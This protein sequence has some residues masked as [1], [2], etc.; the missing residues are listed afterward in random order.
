MGMIVVVP[1]YRH[2]EMAKILYSLKSFDRAKLIKLLDDKKIRYAAIGI[3]SIVI[4]SIIST[5][6]I[7]HKEDVCRGQTKEAFTDASREW[8]DTMNRASHSARITIGSSIS[9]L[10]AIK[11]KTEKTE[12]P[13]CARLSKALLVL[14]MDRDISQLLRFMG[15]E[16]STYYE[17]PY[18]KLSQ[19]EIDTVISKG[20]SNYPIKSEDDTQ[21]QALLL[22][23]NALIEEG[24]IATEK[25]KEMTEEIERRNK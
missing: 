6:G 17:T 3:V 9:E 23:S 19:Q 14:A 7:W 10:Q 1:Q 4:L 16:T 2:T 21:V 5:I 25:T 12:V 8:K 20:R 11:R 24:K 13:D 15:G 18:W 22:G